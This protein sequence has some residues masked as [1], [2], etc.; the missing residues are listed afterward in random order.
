MR[1]LQIPSVTSQMETILMSDET[2]PDREFSRLATFWAEKRRL[3]IQATTA[4]L[5][6]CPGWRGYVGKPGSALG[7]SCFLLKRA[8]LCRTKI[9]NIWQGTPCMFPVRQKVPL[10]SRVDAD[11]VCAIM[12]A[13]SPRHWDN[14][15]LLAAQKEDHQTLAAAERLASTPDFS[16][17][18]YT[19]NRYN[20]SHT[21]RNKIL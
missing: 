17:A 20:N 18:L 19:N 13:D 14:N 12:T 3:G 1:S 4:R 5:L 8:Q 11:K 9:S 2:H 15:E 7:P 10:L 21:K 16:T 6:G